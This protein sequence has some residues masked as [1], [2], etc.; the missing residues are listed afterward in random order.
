MAQLDPNKP[1]RR[2]IAKALLFFVKIHA[3]P[4]DYAHMDGVRLSHMDGVRL[5]Y[6]IIAAAV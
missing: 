3:L 1:P 2:T 5:S 4:L 6:C